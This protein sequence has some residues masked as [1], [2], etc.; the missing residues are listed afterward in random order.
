[1]RANSWLE[2]GRSS[3]N[4]PRTSC[5]ASCCGTPVRYSPTT[6]VLLVPSRNSAI[7]RPW[8]EPK[9]V[10]ARRAIRNVAHTHHSGNGQADQHANDRHDHQQLHERERSPAGSST[11]HVVAPIERRKDLDAG[12]PVSAG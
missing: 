6:T 7:V 9:V 2:P 3:Q 1:M 12:K 10:L 4:T 8:A 11:P 5:G